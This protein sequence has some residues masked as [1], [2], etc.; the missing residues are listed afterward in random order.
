[1]V[2]NPVSLEKE[3]NKSINLLDRAQNY[4]EGMEKDFKKGRIF[5]ALIKFLGALLL[6]IVAVL[7]MVLGILAITENVGFPYNWIGRIFVIVI[8][9]FFFKICSILNK[10]YLNN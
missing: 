6:V 1:M 10:K 4:I 5:R 2:R 7:I 3:V 9:T 8:M